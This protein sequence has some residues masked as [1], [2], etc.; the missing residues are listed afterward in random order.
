MENIEKI[1][2][3]CKVGIK[4]FQNINAAALG[5][6]KMIGLAN[7][8]DPILMPSM[9][10]WSVIRYAKPFLNSKFE[11]GKIC[12]P[13]KNI[14]NTEGFSEEIHDHIITVRNA[15]VAHDDFTEITPRILK[16][17]MTLAD[18]DFFIPTSIVVSN[19]CIS[20]PCSP[21]TVQKM[22]VH[23]QACCN[24]IHIKL[25][26]DIEE[27]RSITLSKPEVAKE[28]QKYS[29][30]YGQAKTEKEGTHMQ[31]PEFMNDEW[32][33]ASVPDYSDLHNGYMYEDARLKKDLHGPE[34]ITTPSGQ[35]LEISPKIPE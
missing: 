18:E 16:F 21:E 8:Q 32:L 5:F 2:R 6:L 33:N 4:A 25:I 26:K 35:V 27:I 24:V 31:P 28:G 10:Y 22:Q 11:G 13:I 17:G 29:K 3:D 15:L 14:K 30:N 12:Y 7:T 34:K 20:F 1:I 19:K 9:F 23:A